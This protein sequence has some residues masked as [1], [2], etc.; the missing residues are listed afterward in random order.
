GITPTDQDIAR[1]YAANQ[2]RYMVPERRVL[3][4]AIVSPD[5]VKAAATPTEAQ[6]AAAYKAKAADY[7]A[8][9]TRTL[10]QVVV[11]DKAS[12]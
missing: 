5:S 10:S 11:A 9:E 7:A 6:I 8:R 12:A 3:R 4:Y 1:W 2:A